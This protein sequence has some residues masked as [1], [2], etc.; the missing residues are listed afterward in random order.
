MSDLDVSQLQQLDDGSKKDVANFIQQQTS[1]AKIQNS[2]T[3]FTDMCFKKCI[4]DVKGGDLNRKEEDCLGNCL[5]RFLDTNIKI[6]QILQSLQ[7]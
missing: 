5:N 3:N 1:K 6:V 2:V 4:T 7:K